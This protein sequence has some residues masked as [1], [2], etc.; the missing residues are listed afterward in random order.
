MVVLL[1]IN[2]CCHGL[3][4]LVQT[5]KLLLIEHLYPMLKYSIYGSALFQRDS[6]SIHRPQEVTEWFEKADK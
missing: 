4:P 2:F 5:D 6:T 3:G 1:F